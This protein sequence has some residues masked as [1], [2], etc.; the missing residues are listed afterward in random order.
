PRVVELGRVAG[1]TYFVDRARHPDTTITPGVVIV[2]CESSLLYFNVEFVRERLLEFIA[3]R[4]DR[5][6]LVVFFLGLVPR[7]DL[8]GA[9]LLTDLHRT[10]QAQGMAFRLADAHGEVREALRRAG[11]LQTYGPLEYAQSVD[12]VL[13]A[14]QASVTTVR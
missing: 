11:F 7:I 14:W 2:R 13:T 6:E 8:A 5:V 10:L 12:E 1:T 3:A 4:Q 9:E